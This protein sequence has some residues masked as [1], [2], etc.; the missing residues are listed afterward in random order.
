VVIV[1][2]PTVIAFFPPV[3]Q[4]ELS[5]EPNT[6]E[7]LADFRY[8]GA[9]VRERAGEVGI[10]FE[11]IHASS[12]SVRCGAKTVVFRPKKTKVGYYFVEPGK[13][14]RVEYGVLRYRASRRTSQR[15]LKALTGRFSSPG[16]VGMLAVGSLLF[17]CVAMMGALY[18][19]IAKRFSRA[20][21]RRESASAVTVH[22]DGTLLFWNCGMRRRTL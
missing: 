10:D 16:A 6:N 14:P 1:S 15:L 5:N 21:S 3:T 12:F 7:A 20:T 17:G 13:S 8:Y 4:A 18:L 9:R 19:S 2:G 22:R 11:E